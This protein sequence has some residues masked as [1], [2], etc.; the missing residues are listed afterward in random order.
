MKAFKIILYIVTITLISSCK[1]EDPATINV[2][3]EIVKEMKS[4]GIPSL[5][6]CVVNDKK[7]AWE[8]TFGYANLEN[9][10]NAS[11]ETIY[12]IMSISKLF[13]AVAV[14]Q[15]EENAKIDLN[16]DVNNYLPFEVRNPRFPEVPVTV[17]MLLTHTSSMTWPLDE[18][19]I[20]DFYH[21]YPQ[22][23]MPLLSEWLPEYI[24]PGGS[25]YKINVWKDY[26]PGTKECYSNIATSLLALI[27]EEISGMDFCDYCRI[28][29]FDPLEMKNSG[30]RYIDLNNE[31]LATPYWNMYSSIHWFNYRAY[32]AGNLKTNIEDFSHFMIAILNYGEYKDK[33]ILIKSSVEKMQTLNNP[34]S[35]ISF[36]W[37]QCPGDCIGHSGGGEGFSSRAEWFMDRG[38]GMF[39]FTNRRNASVYPK[40]RLYELLRLQAKQYE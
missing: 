38:I 5:V 37:D 9:S 2:E 15:L 31:L 11:R 12:T 36:I 30:F 39:V 3:S 13:I 33:R 6:A 18:D 16:A 22:D 26:E 34:T 29:I 25:S 24:L 14:M 27:V 23:E 4:E 32:P 17:R 8:G 40:G 28:N 1:K 19:G 7:V 10:Q 20:T 21:L 35:G